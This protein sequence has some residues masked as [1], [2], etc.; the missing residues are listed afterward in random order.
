[1]QSDLWAAHDILFASNPR[2]AT[3][4]ANRDELLGLLARSIRALALTR[5]E[6]G[7]LP[8][9][10]GGGVLPAGLRAAD[11]GWI[12]VLPASGRLHDFSSDDRRPARVFLKP[13]GPAPDRERWLAEVVGGAGPA[14]D[15]LDAAALLIG[16]LLI[17]D[18][19]SV[20]P[21]PLLHEVQ[22]RTFPRGA[23]GRPRRGEI[24]VAELSRRAAL[25]D[26][27]PGGLVRAGERDP[28]YL[29]AAGNDYFFASERADRPGRPEPILAT[30]RTRCESCHGQ[31]LGV[32]FSLQRHA[33][34]DGRAR[35]ADPASD[36]H[37]G[38]VARRKSGRPDF[39]ALRRAS[40]D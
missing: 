20:V 29:P 2:D 5:R 18:D 24:A 39:R 28:A 3:A 27:R 22:V 31:D 10:A 8:G 30:L 33:P 9:D 4:R 21:S 32:V 37:A 17:A 13:S 15:R 6:I 23:D 16:L 35:A 38:E 34:A 40:G 7:A 36:E 26:R 12:E 25:L 14:A 11:G 1:M 19:G